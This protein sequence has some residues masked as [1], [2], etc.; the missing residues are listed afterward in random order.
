MKDIV[1]AIEL[2]KEYIEHRLK[3]EEPFHLIDA[4]RECGFESLNEYFAAKPLY[5]LQQMSFKVIE[6]SPFGAIAEVNKAISEKEPT[7]IF[8]DIDSTVVWPTNRAEYNAQYVESENLP[9]LFTGSDGNGTL[10]STPGDLGIGIC[11]PGGKA[12]T[13]SVVANGL[14]NILSRYTDKPVYN[15]GN[16]VIVDGRKVCGISSYLTED[17]FMAITPV[18][19]TEKLDL[20]KQICV[21]PMVKEVGHIDFMS[22]DELRWEGTQWLQEPSI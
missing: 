2:E 5:D 19:L 17:V 7:L 20:V 6:V 11:I 9:L 16:D 13:L 10:V 14:V 15:S 12:E 3:G 22:R 18:S 8:V 4:V 21:K 1:R